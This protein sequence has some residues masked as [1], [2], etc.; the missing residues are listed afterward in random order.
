MMQ[1]MEDAFYFGFE[2][3]SFVNSRENCKSKGGKLY[4][5]KDVVE[6]NEIAQLSGLANWF[7]IGLRI[8]RNNSIYNDTT[9]SYN[10][11]YVYD[12]NNQSINFDPPWYSNFG[13]TGGL[14]TCIRILTADPNVGK[15]LDSNCAA[16][17]FSICEL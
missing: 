17:M 2:Q 9:K 3:N 13:K 14:Y 12:S 16:R 11:N 6:M 1:T 8:I 10:D 7:W 5:P 4:E 15:L